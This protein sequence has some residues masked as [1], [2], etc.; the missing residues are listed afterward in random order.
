MNAD[1]MV[2]LRLRYTEIQSQCILH[3]PTSGPGHTH[4]LK[5]QSNTCLLCGQHPDTVQI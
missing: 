1:T 4:R 3:K 2:R 5:L